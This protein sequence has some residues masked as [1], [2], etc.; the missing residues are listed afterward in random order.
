[1]ELSDLNFLFRFLPIFLLAYYFCPA[2]HRNRL[3]FV[4]SLLFYLFNGWVNTLL[5]TCSL[6]WNYWVVLMMSGRPQATGWRRGWLG[7]AVLYNLGTLCYFKYASPA[8]P[9]GISFYTFTMLSLD[10]D[11]YLRRERAPQSFTELGVFGAMFP[12]LLSGPIAKFSDMA[13]QIRRRATSVKKTEQ[14]L[15]LVIAGLSFKILLADPIGILW[16]D[17]QTIGF[18]SISTP[19]AWMGMAAFSVQ[20][21]F[22]FQGYSLMAIGLAYMLGFELPKNF[23]HPYGARSI[24]EYYRRW[25]ISLGHWFRDYLYIPLGGNRGG[26]AR[27]CIN[28]LIVWGITGI[29]H[30]STANFLLWGLILGFF[31]V[32]EKCF[33]GRLLER[34]RALS[35]FYVWFLIPLTWI[36]FAITDLKELGTYFTRLFPFWGEGIA[37]NAR[38][39]IDRGRSYLPLFLGAAAVSC[40]LADRLWKKYWNTLW[41]K[42]LLFLL[43]WVCVYQIVNGLHDPF[44]YGNF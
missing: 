10:I 24:S 26:I 32:L 20:L 37:V 14:G 38:D 25:H 6:L 21:L 39:W 18:E 42:A 35:H 7:A 27:T 23:D 8:L 34:H 22:D 5:L 44:L 19:L 2:R 9:P 4:S 40:P 28:L 12:K 11:V 36:I 29:W 17:V 16:H 33:L 31:I 1:M 15:S 13:G 41:A 43:F 30:G 3:L